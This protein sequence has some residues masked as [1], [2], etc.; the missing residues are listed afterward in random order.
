ADFVLTVQPR[1][2]SLPDVIVHITGAVPPYRLLE[3]EPTLSVSV[4]PSQRTDWFDLGV[5]VRVGDVT[6]PFE[7]LFRALAAGRTRLLLVD[8]SYLSLRQPLF[9]PLAELIAEAAEMPEWE[10]E[11]PTLRPEQLALWHE[12]EELADEAT[13]AAE[14]RSLVDALGVE[15]TDEDRRPADGLTAALRPYQADGAAWMLRHWRHGVGGVL[16][17]DMGL[18]KTLQCIAFLLAARERHGA[19]RMLVVAPTSVV[20][21]WLAEAE[22]FAPGL[23][24]EAVTTSRTASGEE[25]ARRRRAQVIVTSYAVLRR[26]P[27]LFDALLAEADRPA[28]D[29]VIVDEAQA[30]KN[31][32][33]LAHRVLAEVRTRALFAVTGTPIENSLGELHAILSL[34]TPGLLGSAARFRERYVV[35]IERAQPGISEG[36]G[37]GSGPAEHAAERARLLRRLRR[38]IRPVLLRRTKDEVAP[39]LPERQEQVV[40]VPLDPW[41]RRRYTV[42]L[43]RERQKL[44]GLL[45]DLDRNRFTV[46]RSLTLLRLLALDG[47]LVDDEAGHD[48]GRPGAGGDSGSA[49]LDALVERLR[50]LVGEGH[51]ALVFSQF[52]RYLALVE[53]A[54]DSAGIETAYLDGATR[55]RAGAVAGFRDGDGPAVFLISLKAGGVGLTLTE[56][57]Y[58]FLLDPWWN[59]AV[60]NQA[61]DRAHRIG[62]TRPVMVYRMIA[63]DTIEEKVL[64][65]QARKARL[66]DEAIDDHG[67]FAELL[68]AD[69]IRSLLG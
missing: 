52:T 42:A 53:R 23:D 62:Q 49:K 33:T 19:E 59:P 16:A 21:V 27:E 63:E 43:Q 5:E 4:V 38:R 11:H 41:H 24:V 29:A 39:E 36:R 3:G 60:E 58:V 40:R 57:D 64:A 12:L 46:F 68:D 22:R 15:L 25:A 51:R 2:Q 54:L 20:P 61:I 9:A 10:P 47:R 55:D 28:W 45:E 65:L 31:R 26:S 34:T 56:A 35:P 37:A 7:P 13:A 66:F 17:D 32:A 67:E 8:G 50:Q 14:W 30:V 6:I 44:L 69:A 1:L 18:G 48:D